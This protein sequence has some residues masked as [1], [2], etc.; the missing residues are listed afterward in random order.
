MRVAVLADIHANLAA[1]TAVLRDIEQRGGMDELWF[2]GDIVNYGP[3]PAKCIELLRKLKHVAV[4]GNH[5]LAAIGKIPPNLF[6]PDAA[7]ALAWTGRQL[8]QEDANFLNDLPQVATRD[9]F[10]L[11]H[12]S[13]R[14]PVWEYLLSRAQAK[15]NF[16]YFD[17]RFGLVG[18]THEPLI[19]R[20]EEEK[21]NYLKFTEGIGQVIGSHRLLLNPGSVGQ[22]RDGD[23][24]ASY[25][26]YDTQSKVMRLVRVAYEVST[27]QL[28]MLKANLPM[29]LVARLEKGL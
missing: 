8:N 18:H 24:R 1:F 17:T 9:D 15:E 27:T 12:G 26:L 5:D 21:V 10:T 7:T 6:N 11:M 28:K 2:L 29:R 13:P 3:D 19:F 22:P 25:A 23:P 16:S 14:D 20:V 4:A